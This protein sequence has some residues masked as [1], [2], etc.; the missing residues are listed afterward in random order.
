MATLL[1]RDDDNQ[2]IPVLRPKQGGAR[3]LQA[4]ATS[5]RTASPFDP[6][7]RVLRLYATGSVT[8]QT[9]GDGVVAT[10][11][12]HLLPAGTIDFVS[13]GSAKQDRHTHLAVRAVDG[14]A[15]VYLSELE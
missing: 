4:G 7:T 12:S 14:A 6:T 2:P 15:E 3:Y 5:V 1:P 9:G 11:G 10:P 13:L 8:F